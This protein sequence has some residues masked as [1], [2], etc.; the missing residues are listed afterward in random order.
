MWSRTN[1]ATGRLFVIVGL[2]GFVAALARSLRLSVSLLA[3]G[4]IVTAVFAVVHPSLVWR[5]AS[6]REPS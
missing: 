2:V 3:S 1:R 4:A 6:H 5:S